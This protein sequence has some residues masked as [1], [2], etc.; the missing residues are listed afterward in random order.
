LS[1]PAFAEELET[2]LS[3]VQGPRLTT[4][5]VD[6][7]ENHI[8]NFPDNLG[9]AATARYEELDKSGATLWNLCTR[10]KRNTD[11][12]TQQTSV[13]FAMTRLFA[14]MM[15]DAAQSSGKGSFSNG[16]RIM[17]VALKTAKTCLGTM[18]SASTKALYAHLLPT[19]RL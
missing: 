10:L 19:D 18:S 6:K 17:Q 2:Y 4:A 16:V 9:S 13:V 3:A 15:L 1:R 8:Q 12:E 14:F 5:I 7:L 11:L